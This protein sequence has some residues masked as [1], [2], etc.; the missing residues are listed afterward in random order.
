ML[1]EF[2]FKLRFS[3]FLFFSTDPPTIN[4]DII[5]GEENALRCN[6]SGNPNNYTF[7]SWLHQSEFGETIREINSTEIMSFCPKDPTRRYQCNGVYICRA[8]NGV[9][10]VTGNRTQSGKVL[11]KQEGQYDFII[12]ICNC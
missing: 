8:E 11:V 10:D 9:K 5:E 1:K 12:F 4:I 2:G 7:Y 3:T 6:P